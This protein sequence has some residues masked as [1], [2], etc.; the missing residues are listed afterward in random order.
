V[1]ENILKRFYITLIIYDLWKSNSSMWEVASDYQLD[2]GFLQNVIQ[3]SASFTSSVLHFCENLDE[4]WPYKNLLQ[5]FTTRLQYNCS[6]MEL[7]PLLELENVRLSRAK[8]LYNA[9]FKTVEMIALAKASALASS[10]KNMPLV[11]AGKIIKSANVRLN[12]RFFLHI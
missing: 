1:D 12:P 8:Q 7:I 3:S 9:G 2:R 5:E 6:S 4:F 11:A 10:M